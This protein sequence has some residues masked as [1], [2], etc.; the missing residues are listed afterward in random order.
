MQKLLFMGCLLLLVGCGSSGT[1]D[2]SSEEATTQ[3]AETV[4]GP[5]LGV[6]KVGY[7]VDEF[8]EPTQ[9][10]Y[11]QTN[12]VGKFSNSATTN[13]DLR[14]N[15]IMDADGVRLD[16]YEY[17]RNH[18][19]KGEGTVNFKAR[20]AEGNI[21]EFTTYNGDSGANFVSTK[22]ENDVRALLL[23]GGVIKFIATAGKYSKSEYNFEVDASYL[24]NALDE[25]KITFK[26][27]D[28]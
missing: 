11:V 12:V 26:T 19:T 5:N 21:L 24:Q 20:D 6:W 25:G 14:V 16:L 17:A 18:P 10:A 1:K 2:S 23:K 28:N 7:Y 15:I 22:F 27:G 8:E 3:L 4:A 13:S 9:E